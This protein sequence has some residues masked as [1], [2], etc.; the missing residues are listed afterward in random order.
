M[1]EEFERAVDTLREFNYNR[2]PNLQ[3]YGHEHDIAVA[4]HYHTV[5]LD[6]GRMSGKTT[7]C[8][9]HLDHN[10][11]VVVHFYRYKKDLHHMLQQQ[12]VSRDLWERVVIVSDL[13]RR[14][15]I[16]R[17]CKTVFIDDGSFTSERDLD[18]IYALTSSDDR[19][20]QY[21]IFG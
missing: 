21:V 8:L 1:Y 20:Q 12:G 5:I 19:E 18:L 4:R 16:C 13:E 3:I 17:T 14:P 15:D 7:Y 2:R 10:T 9:R 11:I 6:V